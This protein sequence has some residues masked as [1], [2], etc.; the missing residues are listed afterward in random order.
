MH[1]LLSHT[2]YVQTM[3]PKGQTLHWNSKEQYAQ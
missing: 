1:P 3:P 2:F